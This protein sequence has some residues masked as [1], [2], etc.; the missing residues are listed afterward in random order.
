MFWKE[1][2]KKSVNPVG[3]TNPVFWP[4]REN[5]RNDAKTKF[6]RVDFFPVLFVYLFVNTI[7]FWFEKSYGHKT[8]KTKHADLGAK[9]GTISPF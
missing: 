8:R 7:H 1:T 6:F 3:V 5:Q 2:R 4:N 9:W